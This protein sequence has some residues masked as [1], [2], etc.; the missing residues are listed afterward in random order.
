[1][2]ASRM[3]LGVHRSQLLD[4]ATTWDQLAAERSDLVRRHPELAMRGE[5]QE[6][7][8]IAS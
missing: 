3:D 4:M 5:H 6:E 2:L 7:T 1:M 8:G